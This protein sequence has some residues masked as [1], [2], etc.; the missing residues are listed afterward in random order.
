MIICNNV[1]LFILSMLAFR[2]KIKITNLHTATKKFGFVPTT[3]LE[4]ICQI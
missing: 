2:I 1:N 4:Q 3:M